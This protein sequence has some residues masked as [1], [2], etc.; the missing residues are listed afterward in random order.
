[1]STPLE[2]ADAPAPEPT[3]EN[4][5]QELLENVLDQLKSLEN[6][7]VQNQSELQAVAI[8]LSMVI[9]SHIV[10]RE[11]N[12][13]SLNLN[14]TVAQAIEQLLPTQ[15]ITIRVNPMDTVDLECVESC[16]RSELASGISFVQDDS[17]PRGG[18]LVSS[19]EAGLLSTL[20]ARL[21]N[22]RDT[23]LQ[24]IEYARTEGRTTDG[25]GEALRRF[26]DRRK[27][28]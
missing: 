12:A 15:E 13:D 25:I 17:I 2:V 23:L 7:R 21:E 27:P 19:N 24:G 28:E 22:V 11:L 16:Y 6:T 20:E 26:P 10:K 3:S 4:H 5:V 18:C 8:E 14:K 1:M 9:A